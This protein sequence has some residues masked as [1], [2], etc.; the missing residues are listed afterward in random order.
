MTFNQRHLTISAIRLRERRVSRRA[1]KFP[2]ETAAKEGH[3]KREL[4]CP[5]F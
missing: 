2:K 4:T 3:W 1:G 5:V